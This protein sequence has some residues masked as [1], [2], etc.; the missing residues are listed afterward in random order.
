MAHRIVAAEKADRTPNW[1]KWLW[2]YQL[3]LWQLVALSLNIDPD[4]V[5]MIED[6]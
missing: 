4:K 1:D 6:I 5:D 2:K 3:A